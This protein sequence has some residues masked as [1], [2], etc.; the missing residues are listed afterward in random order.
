LEVSERGEKSV[1]KPTAIPALVGKLDGQD[2][3][4]WQLFYIPADLEFIVQTSLDQGSP[5]AKCWYK[6]VCRDPTHPLQT[7]SLLAALGNSSLRTDGNTGGEYRYAVRFLG[8]DGKSP[9]TVYVW[10]G[11]RRAKIVLADR[12]IVG[13]LNGPLYPWLRG[14][15]QRC[16]E[17]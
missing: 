17:R 11:G 3:E 1:S 9:L 14:F 4:R 2:L 13:D 8:Q 16:F 15:V 10:N 6:Y 5:D 7:R 12:V